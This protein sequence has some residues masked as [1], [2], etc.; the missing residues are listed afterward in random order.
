MQDKSLGLIPI[1][2]LTLY[3]SQPLFCAADDRTIQNIKNKS[4]S[5]FSTSL[6]GLLF[7]DQKN[8]W[9]R[10]FDPLAKLRFIHT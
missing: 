3:L 9:K 10:R 7:W 6:D 2:N 5:L 1:L 8:Y 4:N